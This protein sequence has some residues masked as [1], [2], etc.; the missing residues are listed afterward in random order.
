MG[1]STSANPGSRCCTN[2]GRGGIRRLHHSDPTRTHTYIRAHSTT[3][4]TPTS[5]LPVTRLPLA[6]PPACA[7]PCQVKIHHTSHTLSYFIHR[8]MKMELIEGS[9]T[10]AISFVTPGNYPKENILHIKLRFRIV[11]L[12]IFCT[13]NLVFFEINSCSKMHI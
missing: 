10:S 2:S 5:P 3:C 9:E 4:H 11:L 13:F 1:D 8:P 6:P 7:E 12:L